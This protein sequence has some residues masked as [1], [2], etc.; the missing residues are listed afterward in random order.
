MALGNA[1]DP[2]KA[3]LGGRVEHLKRA[4]R[5]QALGFVERDVGFFQGLSVR[6]WSA[7]AGR[8]PASFRNCGLRPFV[9]FRACSIRAPSHPGPEA[10]IASGVKCI[11]GLFRRCGERDTFIIARGSGFEFRHSGPLFVIP[12][13]TGIQEYEARYLLDPGVGRG[14]AEKWNTRV[15]SGIAG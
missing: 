13:K 12:V 14:D 1:S 9:E 7:P 6:C 10:S 11:I 15:D 2:V 3:R 5:R 4:Q 8:A